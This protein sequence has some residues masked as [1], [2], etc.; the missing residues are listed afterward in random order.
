MPRTCTICSNHQHE[1]ID[2]ELVSGTPYRTVAKRFDA[3]APSMFRHQQGHLPVTLLKARE[4]HEVAHA[5]GLLA[6]LQSLQQKTLEIL[7]RAEGTGDLRSALAALRELRGTVELTAKLTPGQMTGK[8][9]QAFDYRPFA[10]VPT[11]RLE[12]LVEKVGQLQGG[13]SVGAKG[14][15]MQIS[16]NTAAL[17]TIFANHFAN[18]LTGTRRDGVRR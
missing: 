15:G 13:M 4:A 18:V 2:Q 3:S 12:A 9:S 11:E 7:A 17:A 10:D 8:S 5:D 6:Q 14:V 1:A 16:W